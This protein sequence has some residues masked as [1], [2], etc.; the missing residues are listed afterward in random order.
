M[1]CCQLSA[2]VAATSAERDPTWDGDVC[3]FCPAKTGQRAGFKVWTQRYGKHEKAKKQKAKKQNVRKRMRRFLFIE[4][5]SISACPEL[6]I[7]W[8]YF[9]S[10]HEFSLEATNKHHHHHPLLMFL[11]HIHIHT[12]TLTHT[13]WLHIN[14]KP[15]GT[16]PIPS[17]AYDFLS[18]RP[19][20]FQKFRSLHSS[21]ALPFPKTS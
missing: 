17:L 14:L 19:R 8:Y 15:C 5:L 10:L 1:I 21:L 13:S 3:F 20:E 7:P 18:Y 11:S 6:A 4:V 2:D 9:G 16:R 12:Q